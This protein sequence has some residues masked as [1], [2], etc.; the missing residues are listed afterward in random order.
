MDPKEII[1]LTCR[2]LEL[3]YDILTCSGRCKRNK[4]FAYCDG[5]YISVYLIRKY[6]GKQYTYE[7]IGKMIGKVLQSGFGDHAASMYC[8][9]VCRDFIK[10]NTLDYDGS[11]LKKFRK[12][13]NSLSELINKNEYNNIY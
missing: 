1:N 4:S 12:V 10:G 11:F 7:Q 5:R 8:E 13:E 6:F 9:S 2:E 3:D